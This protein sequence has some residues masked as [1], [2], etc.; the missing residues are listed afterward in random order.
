M[1]F[2]EKQAQA[3]RKSVILI[4]YFVIAVIATVALINLIA[5]LLMGYFASTQQLQITKEFWF[6]GPFWWLTAIV[7]GVILAGSVWRFSQLRKGGD[8]VPLMLGAQPLSMHSQNALHRRLI[9]VTEE[10]SIAAGTPVPALFILEQEAGINAF[11]AGY[12]LQDITLTVSQGALEQLNREQLQGVIAHEFSHIQNADTRLNMR[13]MALLAGILLIG[14][15]GG[16]LCR[17]A[18]LTRRRRSISLNHRNKGSGGVL[19]IGAAL[20]VAGYIG[21]FFGRLIQAAVSRQREWLADATAVQFTRNPQGIAGALG[22]ISDNTCH[23]WLVNTANA[24]EVNHLCFSESLRISRWLASHPPLDQ[25]IEIIDPMYLTKKR[26]ASNAEKVRQTQTPASSRP[27]FNATGISAFTADHAPTAPNH[28]KIPDKSII[29]TIPEQNFVYSRQLLTTFEQ[30]FGDD[31]HRPLYAEALVYRLLLGKSPAA[32]QA[33]NNV[34]LSNGSLLNDY[35]NPAETGQRLD[36]LTTEL[37]LPLL[38]IIS[39]VIKAEAQVVKQHILQQVKLLVD[40]DQRMSFNEFI[41]QTYLSTQLAPKR[42]KDNI[43]TPAKVEN[44]L[45]LML[46]MFA[47]LGNYGRDNVGA[48]ALF[49]RVTQLHYPLTK[50]VY[51]A[52]VSGQQ[53]TGAIVRLANLNNHM[54]PVL[55]DA[56]LD[57]IAA[58]GRMVNQEYQLLRITVE[59]LDCPMPPMLAEFMPAFAN[60]G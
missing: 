45:A 16:Y 58:D 5:Y 43:N 57:C 30:V 39:G 20:F 25:R 56:C 27:D 23:S 51:R 33:G 12:H 55:I 48:R 13:I 3:K 22:K 37:E 4:A 6:S 42:I 10:I 17:S 49:Q 18:A 36:K 50:L 44:E 29:G 32:L 11:V 40:A 31:L 7:V 47:R 1:D 52:R 41:V 28:T 46:S 34:C 38:E 9:N 24:Q 26:A 35:D 15:I 19:A 54:K 21:L 59:M 53:L 2:F 8:R 60:A 14:S